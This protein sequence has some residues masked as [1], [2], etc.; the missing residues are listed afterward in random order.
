MKITKSYL[1]Q[2][3]KEEMQKLS[4]SE[5]R[6]Y[7]RDDVLDLLD[8]TKDNILI[9]RFRDNKQITDKNFLVKVGNSTNSIII[10]SA[11]TKKPVFSIDDPKHV[12]K[13]L[14]RQ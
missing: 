8:K 5:E 4:E 12:Q 9:N 1:K 14:S 10:L 7:T 2:I 11:N 13:I 6:Q 3:I